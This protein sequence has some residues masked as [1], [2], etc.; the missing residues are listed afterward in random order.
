M[1]Y[2]QKQQLSQ[3]LENHKVFCMSRNVSRMEEG[4]D[5]IAMCQQISIHYEKLK[6][7][8]ERRKLMKM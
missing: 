8:R 6:T 4:E 5:K 1:L 7:K 2:K 3:S